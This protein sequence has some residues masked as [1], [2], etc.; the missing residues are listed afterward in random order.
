MYNNNIAEE[1][2]NLHQ[3]EKGEENVT[4]DPVLL[5]N[6]T[7]A[8]FKPI[9][10]R[11]EAGVNNSSD[12]LKRKDKI[13]ICIDHLISK[14][15]KSNFGI[16]V[17]KGEVYLYNS[18][19]WVALSEDLA[20]FYM[21]EAAERMA[22]PQLE[23]KHHHFRKEMLQ[24]LATSAFIPGIDQESKFT[25]INLTN[26]TFSITK[27]RQF[28]RNFRKEDFMTY[29]LPFEYNPETQAPIWQSYLDKV[30]PDK[31]LQQLLKEYVGY[32]FTRNIDFKLEKM[33]LLYGKGHNGKSV[34]H[35]VIIELFGRQNV[36]NFSLQDLTMDN[37]N[38]LA[39]S[40][41]KLVNISS[42]ISTKVKPDRLKQLASGEPLK[43]KKL[44]KDVKTIYDYPRFIFNCNLL[45]VTIENTDAFFRRFI[46]IPFE[47]K[48]DNEERDIYLARKIIEQEL[49]GVL[50][51]AIE[52]LRE[53]I[54]NE[55][56][57]KSSKADQA[58]NTFV[59]NS[60]P[61]QLFLD[62]SGYI[63]S[64][65]RILR[66]KLYKEFKTY[67]MDSGYQYISATMFYQQLRGLGICVPDS[68][69]GGKRYAYVEVANKTVD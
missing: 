34:F 53:L 56:F 54:M 36:T 67:C 45:P 44:Y 25:L 69:S 46:I 68:N 48:I 30:L 47:I 23:A 66:N 26:G 39:M 7:L 27:D 12:D 63:P 22:M 50:N 21:G 14:L 1:F 49:P 51:W 8:L 33:L 59:R 4:Q 20:L 58:L 52:G 13:I 9:D 64:E 2:R 62:D 19:F 38:S 32:C 40:E 43:G 65:K 28:I 16:T 11:K 15:E 6:K 61:V 29:Q 57:S 37:G 18:Q 55:K 60:D 24:Q 17:R 31:S 41:G 42:E 3:T 5:I 10:F 35:D